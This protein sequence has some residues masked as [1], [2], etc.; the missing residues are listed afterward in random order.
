MRPNRLLSHP[1]VIAIALL[2][3]MAGSS[4]AQTLDRYKDPEVDNVV[5]FLSPEIGD[6]LFERRSNRIRL[7]VLPEFAAQTGGRAG[8]HS[9]F[10]K[11]SLDP[12]WVQVDLGHVVDI[13]SIALVPVSIVQESVVQN[14][15]GFPLRFRVQVSVDPDFRQSS[16]VAD[17]T[18]ADFPN[19]GKYPCEFAGLNV[20]GRYVRVTCTKLA[21]AGLSPFFALG[22][23]MVISGDRNIASWRPVSASSSIE[24]ESRWSKQYLVDELSILPVPTT[25]EVSRTNGYLSAASDSPTAEKWIQIDLQRGFHIDEVR[26]IPARPV[27]RPDIPGWGVPQSF[28]IEVA[29]S[30]DF[31]DAQPLCDFSEAR[32]RHEANQALVLPADLRQA[33]SR[34]DVAP[35]DGVRFPFPSGSLFGRYVKLTT[36]RLDSRNAPNYLALA[37]IQVWSENTN[38]A[39]GRPVTASD[40]AGSEYGQRWSPAF[41]VDDFSSSHKLAS[42]VEWLSQIARRRDIEEQLILSDEKFQAAVSRFWQ[43]ARWAVGTLMLGVASFV[44]FVVWRQHHR[45]QLQTERLRSQIASDLHDDI[46]SNLGTI[47]LL[48]QTFGVKG[49]FEEVQLNIS[50]IRTIAL[51]TGDAMRDILW[52]MRGLSTGLDEFI[53]R[54]RVINSR[55]TQGYET[56]FTSPDPVPVYFVDLAWRRNVFLSFKEALYNAVRHSKGSKLDI[57]VRIEHGVFNIE[58]TDN[59]TGIIAGPTD[60]GYGLGNLKKRLDVL[61]GTVD[62]VSSPGEGTTVHI[63]AP[64]TG[65]VLR[66]FKRTS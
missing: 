31:S 65:K 40:A 10:V 43:R 57:V 2:W 48:C 45:L 56:Q 16:L 7:G 13:E 11:S 19:P 34:G 25:R 35:A 58:V 62:V 21:V 51:E 28:R 14:G 3:L 47:A 36:S 23:L 6:L 9:Q 53:G 5:L 59:G 64:L 29:N 1:A 52:L 55:M 33:F 8:F 39:L 20:Q 18:A 4:A 41:L 24:A 44:A 30:P 46:G 15:Y 17:Q 22:E 49:S 32:V 27:D 12:Q 54:M 50:E 66:R 42:P 60:G 37:E 26:L 61:N 38:V 63:K